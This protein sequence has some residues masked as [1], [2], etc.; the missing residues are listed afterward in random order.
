MLMFTALRLQVVL[1]V[2][3]LGLGM[4]W[5]GMGSLQA[6]YYRDVDP[7]TQWDDSLRLFMNIYIC[8]YI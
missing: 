4:E 5:E 8:I 6:S 7:V 3:S 2:A 1:S